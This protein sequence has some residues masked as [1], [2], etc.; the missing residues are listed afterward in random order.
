MEADRKKME[1]AISAILTSDQLARVKQIGIQL[2]GSRAVLDKDI[3]AQLGITSDQKAKID[4]TVKTQQ[5][6][7]R[8]LFEQAQNGDLD[9]GQ[10]RSAMQ[11]NDKTFQ[12]KLSEILT[13]DQASKLT[14]MGGDKFTATDRE[15][16]GGG[17]GGPGGPPPGGGGGFGP[18]PNGGQ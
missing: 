13:S 9:Q 3:Q 7:N 2:A 17:P 6:A 1:A 18:P 14:A 10:M 4:A 8:S 12:S 11:Q 16:P 5:A 15:G